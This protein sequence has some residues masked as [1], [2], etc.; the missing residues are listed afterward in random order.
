MGNESASENGKI[1]TGDAKAVSPQ[2]DDPRPGLH[3]IKVR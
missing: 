2:V 3:G 1:E